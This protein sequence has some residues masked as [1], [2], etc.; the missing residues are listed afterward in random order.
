[1]HY[2]EYT[3]WSEPGLVISVPVGYK[4]WSTSIL[5]EHSS[6]TFYHTDIISVVISSGFL[7]YLLGC[8]NCRLF[9]YHFIKPPSR[10]CKCPWLLLPDMTVRCDVICMEA[11]ARSTSGSRTNSVWGSSMDKYAMVNVS[12]NWMHTIEILLVKTK[13][14]AWVLVTGCLMWTWG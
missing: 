3:L 2:T 9:P 1:M 5:N 4:P 6:E 8:L 13:Y 14:T 11:E 7:Y 10:I 12:F